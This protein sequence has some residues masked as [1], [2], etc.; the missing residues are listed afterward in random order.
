MRNIK[1]DK[2]NGSDLPIGNRCRFVCFSSCAGMPSQRMQFSWRLGPVETM[3]M[4]TPIFSS[5]N[6]T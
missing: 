1:Q 4:G 6:S 2:P 3:W 5:R